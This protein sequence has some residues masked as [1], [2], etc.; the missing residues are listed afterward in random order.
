MSVLA[1]NID[2]LFIFRV[3]KSL[4]TNPD[5]TWQNTYEFKAIGAGSTGDLLDLGTAVVLFEQSMH[6]SQ[7]VFERLLI[8]TW[9]PDSHPYDPAAFIASSLT[10]VGARGGLADL[11]PLTQCLT[12]TRQA[13]SGRFG[14]IFYRGYLLED[15]SSAP[16]GKPRLTDRAGIQEDMEAAL[17]SSGLD[18]YIGDDARGVFKMCMV[19]ADGTQV[20]DV[21]NLRVQGISQLPLDHKWFN[22]TPGG[23]GG[24]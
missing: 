9:V 5:R 6:M 15:D 18:G 23:G 8:S 22:R 16:A 4:A 11:Q 19:N 21:I 3:T 10:A 14:H 12:V 13:G 7:V 24:E 1:V 20:R 17:A 2:D